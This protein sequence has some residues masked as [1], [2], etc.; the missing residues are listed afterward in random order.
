MQRMKLTQAAFD[1]LKD[2]RAHIEADEG[3]NL[4]V[5]TLICHNEE[6]RAQGHGQS[7]SVQLSW[8]QRV[9]APWRDIQV[10]KVRNPVAA[11]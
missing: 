1:D 8:L 2:E 9:M 11:S 10:H 5:L 3:P 7:Y 4:V 6:V